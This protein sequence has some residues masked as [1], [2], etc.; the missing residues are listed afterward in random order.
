MMP[1]LKFLIRIYFR[2]MYKVQIVGMENLPD[3]E[4]A[5]IAPNHISNL[6]PLLVV[7]FCKKPMKAM[8]KAELFKNKICAAFFKAVGAFPINRGDAD[9][10]AIKTCLRFL[11]KE[12]LVLIFP[13]GTR[14]KPGEDISIKEGVV[15]MALKA[16]KNIVPCYISGTYGFR[17]P[18]TLHI[19]K[20]FDLSSHFDDKIT[21]SGAKQLADEI[22]QAMK[23]L[24]KESVKI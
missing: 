17:K 4:G 13:H 18:I 16:R 6:D 19:G 10:T 9:I 14:I 5:I 23:D 3:G 7:G 22:W 21:P 20:P 12:E 2:I 1:V 8:A 24:D 11:K 15:L